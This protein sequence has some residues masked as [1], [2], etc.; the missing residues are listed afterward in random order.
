MEQSQ[1]TTEAQPRVV[2]GALVG[3]L[4]VLLVMAI[5]PWIWI[6]WKF[7]VNKGL[8]RDK[9]QKRYYIVWHIAIYLVCAVLHKKQS[10]MLVDTILQ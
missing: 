7:K 1:A 4:V 8:K 10:I 6:C 9:Q 5:F 2:I 3:L